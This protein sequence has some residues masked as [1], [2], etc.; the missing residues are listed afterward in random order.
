VQLGKASLASQFYCH[1]G[2]WAAPR[3]GIIRD[4]PGERFGLLPLWEIVIHSS[5]IGMAQLGS[6]LGNRLLYGISSAFGFGEATGIDLGGECPGRLTPIRRW[7]SY[8]TYRLPFGQGQIMVTALQLCNAFA[9]IANGGTL[10]KPRLVDRVVSPDGHVVYQSQPQK[11][12]QVLTRQVARQFIDEALVQVVEKGTG[13]KARMARWHSFG[14]TGTAQI[15]GPHGYQD[16]AFVGTFV[17]GAP[18]T[19][20]GRCASSRCI[21]RPATATMAGRWRRRT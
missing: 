18:A 2:M 9:A 12:R 13:K 6:T 21:T 19:S 11:I 3:G 16:R 20:R 1:N 14:K 10:M 17:A 4:A 15:G 7:T 5:N 8:D